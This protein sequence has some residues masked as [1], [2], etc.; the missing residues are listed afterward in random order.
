MG[1]LA[2]GPALLV[3]EDGTVFRGRAFGAR[4][5]R[6]GEMVFNTSLSGYQEVLTD[7]SYKGQIVAMTYPHIGNT[8]TTPED[9]ESGAPKVEGFVVKEASRAASNFRSKLPFRE[10]LAAHGIPGIEGIDTRALTKRLR[11]RGAMRAILSCLDLDEKSLLAKAL[12]SRQ[13]TGAN[14]AAEV[15]CAAPYEWVDGAA[16]DFSFKPAGRAA[17]PFRVAA[18]DFGI[19][20]NILRDLVETGCRVKVFPAGAKAADI[21]TEKPDGIFLSNGPGDPAAVTEGIECVKALLGKAPL[22]GICLGH[23]ILALALGGRTFKLKFGH[24][25]SNHPVKRLE[26]GQV[27]ITAQNHGFAVDPESL[28][29]LGAQVTH[30]S[31]NDGTVEGLECPAR[32]AFS[33]QYHPEASPGPHDASYLFGRFI[34][35]MKARRGS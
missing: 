14:L 32:D 11:D 19:K 12:A 8:G 25:G 33:V 24:R 17:P 13:M 1:E 15:T 27:E 10:Y 22:F 6:A 29:G 31:L 3:L 18:I 28:Q 30:T 16:C 2:E 7:P 4:A 34:E 23:Q 5:E 20:R 26:T 21:L 9:D 35:R